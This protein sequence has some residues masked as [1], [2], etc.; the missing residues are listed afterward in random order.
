[1]LF[2]NSCKVISL[3][4]QPPPNRLRAVVLALVILL[5][6]VTVVAA[7]PLRSGGGAGTSGSCLGAKATI[8]GTAASDK[9]SGTAAADV[10][11][12]GGGNDTV[13][14]GEDDD[15]ICG[16][17][18]RDRLIG[19]AGN[20]RL[21]GGRDTDRC[22]GGGGDNR[23]TACEVSTGQS[24]PPAGPPPP[25]PLDRGPLGVDDLAMVAEDAGG[26]AID[27]LA[28]DTDSDGGAR[29]IASVVQPGNGTVVIGAGGSDLGYRPAGNYCNSPGPD[30]DTFAYTL[31]G[32]SSARVSVAVTCVDDPPAAVDDSA[33]VAQGAAPAPILVLG[34]D[35]DFDA[36]PLSVESITQPPKG[37]ASIVGAG[38]GLSYAPAAGYCN[39]EEAPDSFTYTLNGGSTAT[40][41]VDVSCVT[42]LTTDQ[43][44]AP[45]FDPEVSDYTLR[46]DGSPL[47]VSGRTA[48]GAT[49][50]IDGQAPAGGPFQALVPLQANQEFGFSLDEDGQQREYHVRCLPSDFP[51]LDYE[52]LL[53]PR[54][55][56]YVFT[57]NVAAPAGHYVVVFD[58]RGV[59][60]WW[61]DEGPK[62][63]DA[64]VLD[65][66]TLAWF[67]SEESGYAIRQLD[68]TLVRTVGFVGGPS[69]FH[70]L[71]KLEN[72]NFLITSYLPRQHADL[73]AFGGGS[74]DSVIDGV[75]E[76]IGPAGEQLWKWST[77]DHVGLA[78]T[79]R[80]W[81]QALKSPARDIVHINAVEADEEDNAI[82]I[83]LRHTDGVYKIDK[84]TGQVIWKLGGTWTPKSL[85]VVGDPEGAY[86]LGGQHDV[87][88]QADGTIT[89]HDNN[90]NQPGPPRAVRYQIDEASHTATMVEQV[91]DPDVPSSFCCGSARRY[92]DGSWLMSWGGQPL[93]T[94]FNG[95]GERTFR[96]EISGG[97]SYRAV[98]A[99]NG[100][101]SAAALRAGM[102]AMHPR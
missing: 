46:C 95:L 34:N 28:N 3:Q 92:G 5:V 60:V 35:L 38:D 101:L 67:Q 72:G 62:P 37:T 59:P 26:T 65:D 48:A 50:S 49:T 30:L 31:N 56:F 68:G 87:R 27:V 64:K 98:A 78:E 22:E 25:G 36:G 82:L 71:R 63:S 52:R 15:L 89:I 96:L 24:P 94:E 32:G 54:H 20:D 85:A 58:D 91:I 13:R 86:P 12:A 29:F 66:G 40:V 80:W 16:G 51:V 93:I 4:R 97:F 61:Y 2:P 84:A 99:P 74:D 23:F 11:A 45:R 8:V 19:A 9:L 53:E 69:D 14:G 18:G 100:V 75:I 90:T 44:L 42:T 43:G 21:N 83:S 81:P 79:G 55:Q 33:D 39:D 73:T 41:S 7:K 1:M 70:E 47:E 17:P 6:P 77:E 10:I 76:E 88:L 102:T 57:T